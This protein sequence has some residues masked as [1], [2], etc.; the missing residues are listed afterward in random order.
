[1]V[2]SMEHRVEYGES[3]DTS[4]PDMDLDLVT[5]RVPDTVAVFDYLCGGVVV[6]WRTPVLRDLLYRHR[7]S[8]HSGF[9]DLPEPATPELANK[10]E[11]RRAYVVA[12]VEAANPLPMLRTK[13]NLVV[14]ARGGHVDERP[15]SAVVSIAAIS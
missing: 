14:A 7:A 10:L 1:M 3:R 15:G 6:S 13:A 2:R 11:V 9:D 4:H 5:E 12:D 8:A